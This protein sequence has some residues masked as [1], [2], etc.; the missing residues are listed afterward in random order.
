M[1][2]YEDMRD[3]QMREQYGDSYVSPTRAYTGDELAE[4]RH[5][6]D[7]PDDP[8]GAQ[9]LDELMTRDMA[10][11]EKEQSAMLARRVAFLESVL[12]D[13]GID[14]DDYEDEEEF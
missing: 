7:S 3:F 14:P 6:H 1:S 9:L 13:H 2:N 11:F 8:G 12:A 5:E 4:F 10:R